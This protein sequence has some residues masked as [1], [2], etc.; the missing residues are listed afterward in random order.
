MNLLCIGVSISYLWESIMWKYFKNLPEFFNDYFTQNN[1]VHHYNAR[2]ANKL[3]FR[4]SRT[5][6]T[7]NTLSN[8]GVTT[9]NVL[10]DNV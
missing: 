7:K 9:W 3:H 2:S 1:E 10:L 5:N 8:K 6:Y 4:Y